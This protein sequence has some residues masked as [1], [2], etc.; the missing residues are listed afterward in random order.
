[1]AQLNR[2]DPILILGAGTLGLSSALHLRQAGHTNITLLDSSD[3]IPSLASAGNDLNKIVRA[4]Y[5]QPFYVDAT[6]DAIEN[7]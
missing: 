3:A 1:M 6:L 4:E 5:E 2:T 7:G